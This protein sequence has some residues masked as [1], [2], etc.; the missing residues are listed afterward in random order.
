MLSANSLLCLSELFKLSINSPQRIP[1]NVQV[2][3]PVS[4]LQ[5]ISEILLAESVRRRECE[6]GSSDA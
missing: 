2:L 5:T 4:D 1:G 6:S 3:I